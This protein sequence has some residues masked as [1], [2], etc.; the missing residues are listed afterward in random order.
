VASYL[1]TICFSY[2][3]VLDVLDLSSQEQNSADRDQ[4]L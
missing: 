4:N 2:E 3:S 1:K